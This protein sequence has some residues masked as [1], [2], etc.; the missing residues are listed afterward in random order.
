MST[1]REAARGRARSGPRPGGD[2]ELAAL[3]NALAHPVRLRILR[4]L[5][6]RQG[7][8]CGAIVAE[9]GLAQS[10][11]SQHLK[12]MR[13]AGLIRGE[14]DGP[15]VCYCLDRDGLGRLLALLGALVAERSQR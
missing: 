13:T 3:L 5:L 1:A 6:A 8:I 2:E 10:T 7:C 11:V 4:L 9:V 12:V 15:R 14:V